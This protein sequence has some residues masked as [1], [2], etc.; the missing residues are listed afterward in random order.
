MTESSIEHLD[1][2]TIAGLIDDSLTNDAR[3]NALEHIESCELCRSDF[4]MTRRIINGHDRPWLRRYRVP[5]TVAAAATIALV[6]VTT[7][8]EPATG[9]RLRTGIDVPTNLVATLPEPGQMIRGDSVRFTW[10]SES[11]GHYVL[12]ATSPTGETVFSHRTNDTVV[13]VSISKTFET[14][15]YFWYVDGVFEDGT[16]ESTTVRSFSIP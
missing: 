8:R 11:A 7:A 9:D 4:V 13:V 10:S 3:R 1:T 16:S 6:F 5:L 14:G 15:T 12:V 2:S